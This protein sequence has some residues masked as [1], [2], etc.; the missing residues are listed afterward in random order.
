MAAAIPD[1]FLDLFSPSTKAFANLA[2]VLSNGSPQV[3]P[4]WFDY[5]GGKIRVNS[6]RKRVKDRV[7]SKKPKVALSITDPAN[8]YRYI[9]VRG[10]VVNVTETGGDAHIDSL[11]KKYLGLDSYPNRTPTETRVIYEIEID[12]CQTMG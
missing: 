12:S 4:V 9:Q 2:L 6:A 7:L 10:H 3:T 5:T 11:S 1:K 8:P